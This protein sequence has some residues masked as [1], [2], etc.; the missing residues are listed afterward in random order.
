MP[1]H[2]QKQIFLSALDL[3]SKAEREEFLDRACANDPALR[4]SIDE[5]LGAHHEDSN[6]LDLPLLPEL[7][8][9]EKVDREISQFKLDAQPGCDTVSQADRTLADHKGAGDFV[10]HYQ[11]LEMIGE[12][13]FGRVFLAQ[14]IEPV[15]RRVAVKLLT[16][17]NNSSQSRN[18]FEAERQALALM[19]HPNI[20]RVFDAGTTPEGQPFFVMELVQG[21]PLTHF[22]DN[23]R[24]TITQRLKVFIPICQAIQHA[25]QK[26]VIH[27]DLKPSNILVAMQDGVPTP[28]VIDFGVSKAIGE[29]LTNKTLH[30]I[31]TSLIGTPMYMSPEQAGMGCVDIDTR[32]DV[33]SLG[34]M[35]FELLTGTTPYDFYRLNEAHLPELIRI[36]RDEEISIPSKRVNSTRISMTALENRAVTQ[37]QLRQ[38]LAGDLDWIVSKAVE[39]DRTRRYATASAL[40]DDVQRHLDQRP[41]EARP[42]TVRYRYYKFAKRNRGTLIAASLVSMAM[43]AGTAVSVWQAARA[44]LERDEKVVALDQALQATNQSLEDRKNLESFI[45]RIKQANMLLASARAQVDNSQWQAANRDYQQAVELVPNYYHVWAERGGFYVRLG[46]WQAAANDYAK[47]LELDAPVPGAD[48][49]GVP[50][51]LLYSGNEAAFRAACQEMLDQQATGSETNAIS[52]IRSSLFASTP[53]V[54]SA[55]LIAW[56]ERL[57]E[58]KEPEQQDNSRESEKI[59][60]PT[61]DLP[62]PAGNHSDPHGPPPD[63]RFGPP[64]PP[65]DGRF[66]PPGPPRDGRS[67][68]PGPPPD[69]RYGPPGPPPDGRLGPPPDGNF[70]PRDRPGSPPPMHARGPQPRGANLYVAGLAYYRAG[71]YEL[72]L[73]KLNESLTASGWPGQM[74]VSPA[75]AMVYFRLNREAEAKEALAKTQRTIDKWTESVVAGGSQ[76]LP[77]PWFD[78]I[79]C[80]LLFREASLLV[81]K[82]VPTQD[83]R[84]YQIE[85]QTELSIQPN[86]SS[87]VR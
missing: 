14:Q 83:P 60:P 56:A 69:D 8:L 42:P 26:G 44:T 46:V 2:Q 85:K 11:L 33:F 59:G 77:V 21:V 54:D 43:V 23:H 45:G 61:N 25:H 30:T 63:D 12:G 41:I 19:D 28:K 72:A 49:W 64:G 7:G 24:L 52:G 16:Y 66:G 84:L 70:G 39:K 67:G 5:L 48:W 13:G 50:Q 76:A 55:K 86:Q 87:T 36:V 29:P 38:L 75:L 47:A 37:A 79:E 62:G 71:K 4:R 65:P 6:L 68:P 35:L 22:C 53:L 10:G 80:N 82:A 57:V 15:R 32:A 58:S 74:I 31:A 9:R 20:A 78:W 34:M 81:N 51:L 73:E 17:W 1:I 3:E 40:A 27:R 18:R